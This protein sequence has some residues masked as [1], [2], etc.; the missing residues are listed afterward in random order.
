MSETKIE[1]AVPV[2]Q[3]WYMYW[4]GRH[5]PAHAAVLVVIFVWQWLAG[6]RTS[7]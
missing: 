1:T 7:T 4:R 5:H 3:A 2:K 6:I